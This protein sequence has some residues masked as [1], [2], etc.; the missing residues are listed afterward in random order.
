MLRVTVLQNK[1][2]VSFDFVRSSVYY[3]QQIFLASSNNEE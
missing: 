2:N 3:V 1:N